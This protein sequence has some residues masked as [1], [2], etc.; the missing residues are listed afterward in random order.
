MSYATMEITPAVQDLL[1][2]TG[3]EAIAS[4]S[5]ISELASA[6]HKHF[7]DIRVNLKNVL[8]SNPSLSVKESYL[9]AY[10]TSLSLKH[11][12]L[13][14]GL[15]SKA[16]AQGA[17]QDEILEMQAVVSLMGANNI[18][19][20]FKHFTNSPAYEN[21]PAN[22]RMSTMLKP[23][24]GKEFFELVSLAISAVTGC[25]MC[26]NAHQESVLHQPEGKT[27]RIFDAVRT[28]AIIGS[29]VPLL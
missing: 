28:S 20:R 17:T 29:L 6:D 5:P 10:A 22:I 25:E 23:V 12:D 18:F 15:R 9:L 27:Q 1:E 3:L 7:R 14:E 21:L 2:V 19:Y 4:D 8:L 13:A 24:T 16:L 26:V 11:K